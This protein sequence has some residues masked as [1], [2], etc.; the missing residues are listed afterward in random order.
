MSDT[1]HNTK[2]HNT[3]S[4]NT[5][6]HNAKSFDIKPHTVKSHVIKSHVMKLQAIF[7]EYKFDICN[8]VCDYLLDISTKLEYFS[9]G[10]QTI[11][12]RY[13][14][15]LIKCCDVSKSNMPT[16]IVDRYKDISKFSWILPI[17]GEFRH[18]DRYIIYEQPLCTVMPVNDNF[19]YMLLCVLSDMIK[20]NIKIQ[21][22][23]FNNFGIY[24]GNIYLFDYHNVEDF[25]TS[26][27]NFICVC[28]FK[29]FYKYYDINI[30]TI[31]TSVMYTEKFGQ[32][33]IPSCFVTLLKSIH[34]IFTDMN[35]NDE[36]INDA[37]RII[38]N[39]LITLSEC[40]NHINRIY[41]IPEYKI[42]SG[43]LMRYNLDYTC[44]FN[45]D[46]F[47]AIIYDIARKY[48]NIYCN[49]EFL[50]YKFIKMGKQVCTSSALSHA[51]KFGISPDDI[52]RKNTCDIGIYVILNMHMLTICRYMLNT[53]ETTYIFTDNVMLRDYIS[54]TYKVHVIK[55]L[56]SVIMM[57]I[58]YR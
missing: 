25:Y 11:C 13:N 56:N 22:L 7:K 57:I 14:D 54:K 47:N 27:N 36:K 37:S 21:D 44:V 1:S 39:I 42:L 2:S 46:A 10:C 53:F 58:N 6:S 48:N 5:K 32:G 18:V 55:N 26:C 43:L 15:I 33:K 38:D 28:L 3:K 34:D 20:S 9:H 35:N 17:K 12:L 49:N 30:G 16:N 50:S 24:N 40:M 29:T 19:I 4:H 8:L 23:C 52:M 51:H 45:C 31:N 41:V